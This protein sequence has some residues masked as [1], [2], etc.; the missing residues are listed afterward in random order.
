LRP[1]PENLPPPW[2]GGSTKKPT[3]V[4]RPNREKPWSP[5]LRPNQGK[6]STFVLRLNQETRAPRL[7]VHGANCKRCHL[8]S[9]LF[10]HRVLDLCDYPRSFAPGL[11]LLPRSS[12]LPGMSHLQRT[13]HETSKHSSLNETKVNVK[14]T[15]HPGFEFKHHQVNDSSQ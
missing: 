1:K 2:F 8:T 15:N 10:G 12:S 3:P 9:R 6:P 4:L 11:L 14:Q 13:H 7:H 5:V